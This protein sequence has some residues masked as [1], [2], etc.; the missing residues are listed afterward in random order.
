MSAPVPH[1]SLSLPEVKGRE[2]VIAEVVA[3]LHQRP[4]PVWQYLLMNVPE[5]VWVQLLPHIRWGLWKTRGGLIGPPSE[6][7]GPTRMHRVGVEE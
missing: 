3:G 4:V 7:L 5:D 2:R 6:E 1:P